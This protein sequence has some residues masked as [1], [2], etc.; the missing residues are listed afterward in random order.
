M[1]LWTSDGDLQILAGPFMIWE[2]GVLWMA[3]AA[4]LCAQQAKSPPKQPPDESVVDKLRKEL[5][6]DDIQIHG[7]VR[8]RFNFYDDLI[9]L[10]RDTTAPNFREKDDR[11]VYFFDLRA[12]LSLSL[13]GKSWG[14]VI[15]MDLAGNDFND[16]GMLG[17][18]TDVANSNLGLG[19][20]GLSAGVELAKEFRTELTSSDRARERR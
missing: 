9:T 15:K 10:G 12:W 8:P 20:A 11:G 13:L 6:L 5:G 14:L 2:G 1:N 18:D 16:G 3:L 17:N 19:T 7:L 4:A